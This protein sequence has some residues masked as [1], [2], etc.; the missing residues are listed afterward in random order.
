MPV[1]TETEIARRLA[2][3]LALPAEEDCSAHWL[4]AS[5]RPAAVLIPFLF[6]ADEWHILYTRRT[7]RVADHKGQVAFPGGS[8]DP[9]DPSA[10]YTAL[11]EAE[12]EIGLNPA[13]VTVLGRLQELPTVTHYCI[14]PVIGV[15][16]WPYPLHLAEIEVSRA[17]TIPLTWLADSSHH[18]TRTR[19]LPGTDAVLRVIYFQPYDKELLWGVTAQIT[20]N[21]LAALGL[22]VD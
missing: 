3:A 19:Y 16:P 8:A 12:E 11:R 7:D 21:L 2:A 20:L 4:T 9:D 14:T 10:E 13:D 1:L 5:P 6:V 18:E 22:P 17:F 15:I